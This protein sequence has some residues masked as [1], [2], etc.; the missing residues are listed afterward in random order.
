MGSQY[1]VTT[2]AGTQTWNTTLTA[3][4]WA[5]SYIVVDPAPRIQTTATGSGTGT[6][7]ASGGKRVSRTASGSGVGSQSAVGARKKSKA[8]AGFGGGYASYFA[9]PVV[10]GASL[11]QANPHYGQTLKVS[12]SGTISSTYA[13]LNASS[14]P[15]GNIVMQIW[16][17]TSGTYGS[18][19]K[20]AV[21]LATS[22]N[23]SASSL[24]STY[25]WYEFTFSGAN[26]ISLTAGTTYAVLV[27]H[28]S[29]GST[30][31]YVGVG[32][33]RANELYG[34]PD[35]GGNSIYSGNNG[36]SFVADTGNGEDM[37]YKINVATAVSSIR[38][39]RA[40]TG[41]GTGTQS[42]SGNI[43]FLIRKKYV[44]IL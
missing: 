3:S 37:L 44:L 38:K 24:T 43:S 4:D 34:S 2:G 7:S 10:V 42:G 32:Y 12:T 41:S 25:T 6:Q 30:T 36:T 35:A 39:T 40:A 13:F 18:G 31:P 33:A 26:R 14:P 16:S 20:P 8:A 29:A 27:Y 28:A 15:S 5:I 9:P 11:T 1:K 22:N 21:L 23:V 19:Q 17:V